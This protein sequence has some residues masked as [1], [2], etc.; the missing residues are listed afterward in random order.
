[1]VIVTYN[2]AEVLAG[3]LD[4]LP[5]GARGVRLT[6]VVVADNAS[7]D[8]SLRIAKEAG[9]LPIRTVQLGRNAGYAAGF[10]AGVELLE[11]FDAVVLM[12]P[13][14]RVRPGSLAVLAESLSVSG[15][16]I[17]APRLVNPDGSLQPTL[18][19][20]PTV[21]GALAEAVLGGERAGRTG[22]GELIF[23]EAAH[24]TPG[25]PAWVTGCVLMMSSA[26][27][28]EVGPWDEGFLLY[29]E[30]TEFIFRAEDHGWTLWYEPAAVVE[31]KG[32]ESNT[33]PGLAALLV[34][35]KVRLFRRSN[36]RIR[37]TAYFLAV[38]LGETLRALTGRRTA[39]ESVSQ[40]LRPARR[41]SVLA[42]LS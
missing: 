32:G 40:L 31:H 4:A 11:D 34:V 39:R 8:E 19:R 17:V 24:R 29:S 41:I 36:G 3:C 42:E 27:L 16:G 5:A 13:D 37:S 38:L 12:N 28:R 18:R 30:E 15:R 21:R 23:D 7:D 33:H 14:C 1:V 20:T 10:N 22:L 2:S 26:A 25:Q 35:N 6:D 9:D